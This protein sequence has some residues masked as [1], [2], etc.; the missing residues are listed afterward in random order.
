MEKF[1]SLTN[2]QYDS[3]MR[4][5]NAIQIKNRHLQ[6]EHIN[7]VYS[8]C[9]SL[10]EIDDE[11]IDLSV[12]NAHKLISNKADVLDEY[13]LKLKTLND[14][15]V[16]ILRMNGYSPEYL[17]PVYDCPIC[18]DTGY[19]DN[20]TCKCFKK[21]VVDLFY[22]KSNLKNFIATQNFETF[23][24]D[25]YSK[26][27]IDPV[28]NISAYDNIVNVVS[29]CHQYLDEFDK[30][31]HNLLIYGKSGVGKTFLSNCIA[32]ELLESSHSVIYLTAIEF[33]DIF[34]N[35]NQTEDNY[36]DTAVESVLDCDLLIIDDLGTEL[37]N[38]FTNSKLF[39]CINE[40]MLKK[41]STIISTN[42]SIQELNATYSERI[43]SRIRSVYTI[44]KIFGD[45]I[46]TFKNN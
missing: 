17:E 36:E 3:I 46:R 28:T 19:V 37:S 8:R 35:Y 15:K 24:Y 34:S 22:A 21:K 2:S 4:I 9:P 42:L 39:Y 10:K 30:G 32:K 43:I 16:E 12:N 7:E 38:S 29:I 31:F 13:K 11:I 1:M 20:A 5:Y 18:H 33:F 26:T 27:Y 44:L 41:R 6:E 45:D 25:Y 40:R 23:S 14:Q